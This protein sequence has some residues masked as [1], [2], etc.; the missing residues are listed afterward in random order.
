MSPSK[1]NNNDSSCILSLVDQ[2]KEA[3]VKDTC[4]RDHQSHVEL[5]DKVNKLRL[6][7]ETPTETVLRIIYQPPQ[8]AALRIVTDLRV[9]DYLT[10]AGKEGHGLT[11]A[12]IAKSTGAAEGLIGKLRDSLNPMLKRRRLYANAIVSPFDSPPYACHG[13]LGSLQLSRA[14]CLLCQRED[15][16][17]DQTYWPRWS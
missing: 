15:G 9:F 7:V 11:A 1:A 12:Q 2:V 10:E 4:S 13:F 5:L 8:N 6:A 17:H 14:R 16:H 3:A